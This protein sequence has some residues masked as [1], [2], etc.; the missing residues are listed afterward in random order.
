VKSKTIKQK[1]FEFFQTAFAF[2][3]GKIKEGFCCF[4]GRELLFLRFPKERK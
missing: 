4:F 1:L 3:S 2:C